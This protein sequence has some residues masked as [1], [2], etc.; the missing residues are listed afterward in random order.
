MSVNGEKLAP[1]AE[2]DDG[3]I[4][5]VVADE[6]T[7]TSEETEI[8]F[9]GETQILFQMLGTDFLETPSL[10]CRAIDL[11]IFGTFVE[12]PLTGIQ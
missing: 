2:N 10:S 1:H 3:T 8:N 7:L 9:V 6:P 4:I 12:D 5:L 11:V